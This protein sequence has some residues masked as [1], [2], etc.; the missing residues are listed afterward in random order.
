MEAVADRAEVSV[1]TLYNYFDSKGALLVGI[2]AEATSTVIESAGEIITDP[3]SDGR[4]AIFRLMHLY[5]DSLSCLD[6]DLLRHALSIS[7][8]SPPEVAR[9]MLRLDEMLIERTT[10][11]VRRLQE[12]GLVTREL[13]AEAAAL[14]LYASFVVAMLLWIATP[15]SDA[16]LLDHTMDQQLAVVF[17]G[18]EPREKR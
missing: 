5:A 9:Q 10:A 11:L 13:P 17:R 16:R 3:G 15:E 6:R 8:T 12:L 14:T 4:V 2:L 7:F 18:L 1:G